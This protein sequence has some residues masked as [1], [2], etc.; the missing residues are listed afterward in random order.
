M[1]TKR[2][3][4]A[5][6]HSAACIR[7]AWCSQSGSVG[8]LGLGPTSS[9]PQQESGSGVHEAHC[10]GQVFSLHSTLPA[11]FC[12]PGTQSPQ[13]FEEPQVPAGCRSASTEH[14][15]SCWVTPLCDCFL[16]RS[17]LLG[18]VAQGQRT[19]HSPPYRTS[20]LRKTTHVRF[21]R[22]TKFLMT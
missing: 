13:C 16:E 15:G 8:F 18:T 7:G 19:P 20:Q 3:S 17:L 5:T 11:C 9:L 12:L 22:V 2:G 1:L 10:C 4:A 21:C 6:L 14:T